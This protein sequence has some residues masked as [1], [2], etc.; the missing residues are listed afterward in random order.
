MRV[1][2]CDDDTRDVSRLE[3]LI[4]K[5]GTD[6]NITFRIVSYSSGEELLDDILTEKNVDMIFLDINLAGI[7]RWNRYS[8]KDS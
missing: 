8:R 6:N 3:K 4:H 2:L 1:F 5:Y 7:D